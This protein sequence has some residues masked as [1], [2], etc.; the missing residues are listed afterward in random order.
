[1]YITPVFFTYMESLRSLFSRRPR[2]ETPSSDPDT[3][4]A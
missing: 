3:A 2:V 4:V 1:L